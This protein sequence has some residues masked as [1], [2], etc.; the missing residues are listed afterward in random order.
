MGESYQINC[1]SG[2]RNAVKKFNES[3]SG[4]DYWHWKGMKIWHFLSDIGICNLNK[5]LLLLI[6]NI[7]STKIQITTMTMM[8]CIQENE[9]I[10]VTSSQVPVTSSRLGN[11]S[12]SSNHR[13]RLYDSGGRQSKLALSHLLA[14]M[15]P[16]SAGALWDCLV[17]I[18]IKTILVSQPQLY[19][20]YQ[21]CRAA[22]N[23]LLGAAGG[24]RSK[25]EEYGSSSSVC[26][27]ILGFD[28]VID[29]TLRPFLL[30]V[31]IISVLN[32]LSVWQC[33]PVC[34]HGFYVFL[35]MS[36]FLM[37]LAAWNKYWVIDGWV[38]GFGAWK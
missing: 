24:G 31:F 14:N 38:D 34:L 20:S 32:C 1:R 22:K 2:N 25:T 23:A 29:R 10:H 17:D 28:L 36:Y 33:L 4:S 18:V 21:L 8:I 26:F 35:W 12:D 5:K 15:E 6:W 9:Q 13:P 11:A 30:E 16:H 27:E 3:S 7:D 19:L 37:G